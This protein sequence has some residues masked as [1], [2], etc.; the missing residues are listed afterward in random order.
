[1]WVKHRR[2]R[3]HLLTGLL[4]CL[5]FRRSPFANMRKLNPDLGRLE[6]I[7]VAQEIAE[8]D[9]PR[10]LHTRSRGVPLPDTVE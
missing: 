4:L 2:T 3:L 1:M 8:H 9:N 10:H 6:P 7:P 5:V